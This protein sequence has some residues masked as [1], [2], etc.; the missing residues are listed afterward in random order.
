[1]LDYIPGSFRVVYKWQWA[2]L[3]L[4]S[5]LGLLS[6]EGQGMCLE[7]EYFCCPKFTWWNLIPT[8]IVFAGAAYRRWWGHEGGALV[9]GA[10]VLIKE[11]PP[12]SVA[13]SATDGNSS[14]KTA[15]CLRARKSDHTRRLVHPVALTLGCPASRTVRTNCLLFKAA[16]L[17]YFCYSN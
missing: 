3:S 2:G 15:S 9:S 7:T 5:W 13:P 11:M 17:W 1:M 14:E 16:S 8:V 12:C 6:L 10:S 4:V